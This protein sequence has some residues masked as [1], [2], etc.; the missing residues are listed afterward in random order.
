MVHESKILTNFV[1]RFLKEVFKF[2]IQ[3]AYNHLQS[4]SEEDGQVSPSIYEKIV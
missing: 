3:P 4:N 1:D 2:E